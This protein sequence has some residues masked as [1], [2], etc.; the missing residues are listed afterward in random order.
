MDNTVN[1]IKLAPKCNYEDA[2]SKVLQG[3]CPAHLD[4][5]HTMGDCRG[6][7]SIYC[8]DARKRQHGSDKDSDKN[9]CRDDKRPDKE[10]KTEE[11]LDKDSHHAYKDPDRSVHSIF[12]G[13]VAL[14][15]E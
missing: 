6:L 14:E 13:K 3:P 2:Y 12:G 5:G 4:S 11:E 9:D 8:S 10:D 7:K 1:A 15:N